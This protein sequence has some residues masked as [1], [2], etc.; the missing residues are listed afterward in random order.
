MGD[1]QD[2]ARVGPQVPFEPGHRLGVEVVGGLVEEQQLRL[3]EEELAERDAA[4]LAAGQRVHGRLVRRAAERVH[5][6]VDLGI[7]VPQ[8]LGLDLVLE[9]RHL[10]GG[11]VRVVHGEVVVAVQD[12]LRGSDALHDVLAHGLSRVELRLL[13]QVADA[14][15][16]R[17]PGLAGPL[18]VEAGHDAE[19]RRLAGA[20]RAEHADLG[21][22]VEGEMDVVQH[23][24]VARIGLG[25][26][27]HVIDE[28]SCHGRSC[29]IGRWVW[30]LRGQLAAGPEA[31]KARPAPG[32]HP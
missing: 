27:A 12:R 11:L 2:G 22:G 3:G 16:F 25:D 24:A 8:A 15:A 18:G 29:P 23:L 1:D 26:A 30:D 4:L 5:G 31:D 21:V 9:R 32:R 6:L 19:Q 13:G 14:G 7:E 20:V 10:V 17:D 28:L